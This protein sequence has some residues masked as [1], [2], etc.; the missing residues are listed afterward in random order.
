MSTY[1]LLLNHAPDRYSDLSDDEYMAIIKDYVAW[2]EELTAQGI[3]KDGHKLFPKAGKTLTSKAGAIEVHDSPFAEL[4]EVLGGLM[5]LQADSFEH[6]I[7]IAKTCPHMVHNQ[8][9]E[10]REVDSLE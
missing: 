5:L 10:I 8:S 9:L 2:V 3:Y 4:T 1:A 7:E 6:A